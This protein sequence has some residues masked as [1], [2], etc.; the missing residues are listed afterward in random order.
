MNS[1]RVMLRDSFNKQI[2]YQRITDLW[3]M[4][5]FGYFPV[6]VL[7]MTKMQ[8]DSHAPMM[9]PSKEIHDYVIHNHRGHLFQF[10]SMTTPGK[11]QSVGPVGPDGVVRC[12]HNV[13]LVLLTSNSVSNPGR[14]FY[15]C[16]K[17]RGD[18]D[19]C[20][21]FSKSESN[22]TLAS[23]HDGVEPRMG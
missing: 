8:V 21:F 1:S 19:H 4:L 9:L 12:F 13:E 11:T 3:G 16:F 6:M 7:G 10:L 23:H 14:K 18:P 20:N 15:T 5:A 2:L 17:N 22:F